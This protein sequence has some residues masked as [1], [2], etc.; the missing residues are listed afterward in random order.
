MALDVTVNIKL[1]EVVGSAGTW[2]PCLYIVNSE[3]TNET[4]DEYTKLS[5]LVD[6]QSAKTVYEEGSPV[7][8]AASKLFAQDNA[9]SKIAVLAQSAFSAAT[10]DTYA[11]K[12]WRQLVLVGTHANVPTIAEYVEGTDKLMLF[13]GVQSTAALTTLYN[14]VSQYDRTFIVYHTTDEYAAAAVVGATAGLSAGSFTYKNMKIK[15]VVANELSA[16]EIAAIHA[17]GAVAI[18][19]KVGDIVTSEGKVASGQY[20]DVVDSRDFVIQNIA[21]KTQKVFNNNNKVPYT[22]QGIAMLETA[23]I[24]AL[25]SAYNNGM[26]ADNE[27]GTPGYSTSFAMRSETTE[28]DR[29]TRHYPYGTF[30]FALAGAVHTCIINGQITV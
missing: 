5:E 8:K 25:K 27:D 15:G 19:E 30:S 24:E 12:G 7:Y 1:A 13:T 10:M 21:Y 29:S 17:K 18:V 9:P 2:F 6:T 20:A 3:L 22:N 14:S 11:L 16:S 4:Y 26:I 28:E 23:T